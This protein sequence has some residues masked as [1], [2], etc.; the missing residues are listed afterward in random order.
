[1]QQSEPESIVGTF[2][3]ENFK[4]RTLERIYYAD[5]TLGGEYS[6]KFRKG[7][8]KLPGHSWAASNRLV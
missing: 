5:A 6:G 2:S 8:R 7:N 1:V 3:G 4:V